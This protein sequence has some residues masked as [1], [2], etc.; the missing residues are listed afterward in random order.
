MPVE[1]DPLGRYAFIDQG[2]QEFHYTLLPHSGGWEEAGT[3]QRAAE[4]NQR[5]LTLVGTCHPEGAL[6]PSESFLI[7]DCDHVV[8]TVLKQA[9]DGEDLIVRAVETSRE[10]TRAAICLPRWNRAIQADFGPCEIK[11][12]RVPKDHDL[13]VVETN[14]LEEVE[15]D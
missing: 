10:G 4:L 2:L 5:P 3:V 14:L 12:F 1:P 7:V 9:E 13:P 15:K 11:T 8:V 6:P